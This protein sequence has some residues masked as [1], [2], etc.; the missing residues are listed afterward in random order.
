M[1]RDWG[2]GIARE[3]QERLFQKFQQIDS[4]ATRDVG[5]TGL[6]LAISKALVEEQGGR[7]WLDSVLAQ[8]STFSFTLPLV[9]EADVESDT[10]SIQPQALL[11]GLGAAGAAVRDGLRH[12]GWQVYE[13]ADATM[14]PA[15]ARAASSEVLVVALPAN[16][17]AATALLDSL[18]SDE[19]TRTMLVLAIGDVGQ[20]SGVMLLPAE[21]SA[22]QIIAGTIAALATRQPHVLVVDDDPH[23]RPVLVRLLQRHGLRVT[24]VGDGYTALS[25]IERVRPDVVLL[26]VKMPGIDGT[27]VLRRIKQNPATAAT[28]V[29]ILTANDLGDSLQG[30]VLGLGADG[31]LEK[32]ITY[33]RLISAVTAAMVPGGGA[34]GK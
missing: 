10:G 33:E 16:M 6:G 13:I 2:R 14:I 11:A 5:G 27:E 8:G 24:N 12:A 32:P 1:V 4:S 22:E 7:I 26:D 25:A 21:A 18:A 28:R 9:P 31:Y 17:D 30:Q 3:D 34:H 23:V 19:A 29:I 15:S 20:R